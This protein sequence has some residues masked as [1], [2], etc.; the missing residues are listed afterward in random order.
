M[1][2]SPTLAPAVAGGSGRASG[3]GVRW[4]DARHRIVNSAALHSRPEDFPAFVR[5]PAN[6]E[7]IAFLG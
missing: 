6:A 2:F 3:Y 1:K 7:R 5:K 4:D